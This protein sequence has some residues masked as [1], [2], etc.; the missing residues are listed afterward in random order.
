[1]QIKR[2]EV[3][4][5]Q[6]AIE[7][8]KRDLG[9]DAVIISTRQVSSS[10]D[11]GFFG[12]PFLE[13]VAAADYKDED[14][15]PSRQ[16][17]NFN[18]NLLSPLYDDIK[19][20]KDNFES[21]VEDKVLYILNTKFEEIK[22]NMDEIKFNLNLLKDEKTKVR[23]K[24]NDLLMYLDNLSF[25]RKISAKLIEIFFKDIKLTNFKSEEKINYFKK[26]FKKIIE[27][28][29]EKKKLTPFMD[30]KIVIALV[31]NSGVGKT[32]TAAKLCA[33]FLFEKNMHLSVC[34]LDSL[35]MGGYETLKNYAKKLK[36]D[37]A[38]IKDP[39]DLKTF[40]SDSPSDVIIIDTFAVNHNSVFQLNNLAK[41]L[42]VEGGKIKVELLLPA[43]LKN[44]DAIRTY[45]SFRNKAGVNSIIITKTDESHCLGNLAEIFLLTDST[46]D[47]ITKGENVPEDIE[48]ATVQNIY[49]LFFPSPKY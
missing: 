12:K 28:K 46:V 42:G 23:E 39:E 17:N 10:N 34:S 37:F 32:A 19:F 33:K 25:D 30:N 47:F 18:Q 27:K 20:L 8:I 11:L 3:L 26:F 29:I 5:M 38:A 7:L 13:V 35:K 15:I 43:Q 24:E 48:E 1:M 41:F 2:Y 44:A 14:L 36:I 45:E 6:D 22:Q 9:E 40:I 16:N 21:I 31:G 4:D 49:S